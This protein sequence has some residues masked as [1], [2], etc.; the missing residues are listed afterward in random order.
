[1]PEIYVYPSR[2]ESRGILYDQIRQYFLN[3]WCDFGKLEGFSLLV[4][5]T[6][7]EFSIVADA[8]RYSDGGL[9]PSERL[10]LRGFSLSDVNFEAVQYR[11]PNREQPSLSRKATSS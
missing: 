2:D 3:L 6:C 10:Y 1:M 9:K 8:D 5:E 4:R 7:I 11:I